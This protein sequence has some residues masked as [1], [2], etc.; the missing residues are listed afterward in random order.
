[1][2]RSRKAKCRAMS[3]APVILFC[4]V[5][6]GDSPAQ[7][8][9]AAK[10]YLVEFVAFRY[11]G[12]ANSGG[13]I[14]DKFKS[15]ELAALGRRLESIPPTQAENES[16]VE[17]HELD[18][19][20]P[21]REKI[22]AYPNYELLAARAWLQPLESKR[23]A[24][25]IPV[26]SVDE[27]HSSL[28]GT[29]KIYENRL[30]FADVSLEMDTGVSPIS[31]DYNTLGTPSFGIPSGAPHYRISVTRRIRLNETHYFDHPEFGALL[32]VSRSETE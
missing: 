6:F 8:E 24:I 28:R 16:P 4:V 3:L 7:G 22:A 26:T 14:W 15:P 25:E 30:L 13:E 20:A 21:A 27:Q 32:R 5:Y 23:A 10:R 18:A 9:P 11:A 29:V 2:V 17:L 31:G 19:L 1:M 12:G